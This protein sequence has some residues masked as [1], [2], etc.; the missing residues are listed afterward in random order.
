M[1]CAIILIN[2]NTEDDIV[3][4]VRKMKTFSFRPLFLVYDNKG[5]ASLAA[6][7]EALSDG[8]IHYYADASNAGYCFA[9]NF[10]FARIRELAPDVPYVGLLNSD[11][12]FDESVFEGC[13]AFLRQHPGYIA[14]NPLILND[15]GDYWYSGGFFDPSNLT[16]NANLPTDGMA[17]GE[18]D[19]YNGCFVLFSRQILDFQLDEN[20][21][22]YYEEF[23]VSRRIRKAG[24]RIKLYTGAS[25]VHHISQSLAG[26]N[27]VKTY[28]KCRNYLYVLDKDGHRSLA[29]AY[30][31][32]FRSGLG[33]LRRGDFKSFRYL[34]RGMRDFKRGHMGKLTT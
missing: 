7:L 29:P 31:I 12:E 23:E 14:V 32:L 9:V 30:G 5:D 21:F 1:D 26:R 16:I 24:F 22:M 2:Y 4:L 34:I 3:A 11:I 13:S 27:Y 15:K 20:L 19:F 28:Y 33:H 18:C 17:A 8:D 25:I 10:C 6:R